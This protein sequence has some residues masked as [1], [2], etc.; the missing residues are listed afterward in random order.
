MLNDDL[1]PMDFKFVDGVQGA[2][3]LDPARRRCTWRRTS[4]NPQFAYLTERMKSISEGEST[5]LDNSILVCASSLFDGDL[6]S[7]EQ[8]PMLMTG[9]GE[10]PS[11]LA[12]SSTTWTRATPIARCAACTCR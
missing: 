2:L 1:S 8:L 4:S 6:H 5:L 3:H 10:A 12:A 7:A 9:K 11:R